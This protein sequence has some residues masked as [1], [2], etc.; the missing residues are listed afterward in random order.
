L[1]RVVV[2]TP[3]QGKGERHQGKGKQP[4]QMAGT[5]SKRPKNRGEGRTNEG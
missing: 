2:G 3:Q 1:S 4:V 5:F